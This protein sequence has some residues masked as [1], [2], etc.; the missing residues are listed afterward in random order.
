MNLRSALYFSFLCSLPVAA[1]PGDAILREDRPRAAAEETYKAALAKDAL[2][3]PMNDKLKEAIE[4]IV[5]HDV[6]ILTDNASRTEPGKMLQRVRSCESTIV[7]MF[8]PEA[9]NKDVQKEYVSRMITTSKKLLAN[10][11]QELIVRVNAM[12]LLAYLAEES[13]DETTADLLIEMIRAEYQ[14]DG[15]RYYGFKGLRGMMATAYKRKRGPTI[16]KEER[17]EAVITTLVAFIERKF[18]NTMLP[19]DEI[20]GLQMVRREAIRALAESRES[21]LPGKNYGHAAFALCRV[22]GR[23]TSLFPEPRFDERLEA[24]IGLCQM[25]ADPGGEYQPDYAAY[26]IAGFVRDFAARYKTAVEPWRTHG[27]RLSEAMQQF[28]KTNG[29]ETASEAI[30]LLAPTAIKEVFD[31]ATRDAALALSEVSKWPDSLGEKITSKSLYKS[32]PQ[33]VV[34]PRGPGGK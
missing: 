22:V 27:T 3:A 12:K 30:K 26:F 31:P 4:I 18:P 21:L 17:R 15:V 1:Q 16:Q 9:K 10:P 13:G 24:A 19:P 2:D 28:Y 20:R 23:D 8:G 11:T 14:P 33:A 34:T 25:P 6:Y 7:G 5:Q 29:G 32:E